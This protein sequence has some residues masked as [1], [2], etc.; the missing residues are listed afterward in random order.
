M[1][2]CCLNFG[3]KSIGQSVFL[4]LSLHAL[5][6]HA[7]FYFVYLDYFTQLLEILGFKGFGQRLHSITIKYKYKMEVRN[8]KF[9]FILSS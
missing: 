4:Y 5:I 3:R 7:Y 6:N 1:N 8:I 9:K 2:L